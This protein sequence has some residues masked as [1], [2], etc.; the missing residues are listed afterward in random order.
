GQFLGGLLLTH[1]LPAILYW[2]DA[3]TYFASAAAE[4]LVRADAPLTH[5]IPTSQPTNHG[6]PPRS[7]IFHDIREGF[8]YVWRRRGMR[9]L[10]LAAIPLNLLTTPVF[11]LLP[12]YA[13]NSL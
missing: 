6:S 7:G 3:G 10:L 13:T 9:A 8:S 12:F 4:S 1:Y 5:P 11:L 2:V